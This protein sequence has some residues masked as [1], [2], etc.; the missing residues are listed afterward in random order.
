[1][2]AKWEYEDSEEA[3]EGL[4]LVFWQMTGCR[5]MGLIV[6]GFALRPDQIDTIWTLF[7]EYKDLLLLAR[8]GF[9]KSFIFQLL[10]F[11]ASMTGVMILTFL[12]MLITY[13]LIPHCS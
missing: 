11:M 7:Y 8:M 4:E 13:L 5:D 6:L 1:M 10:L 9:G 12:M 2:H 3:V